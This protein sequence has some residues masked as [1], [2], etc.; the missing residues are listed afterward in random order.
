VTQSLL[1]IAF[2]GTRGIPASHGGFE[3]CA[4]EVGWRLASRGHQVTVY[5]EGRGSRVKSHRGMRI[6]HIPPLPL[7]GV[8][9]LVAA[10]LATLHALLLGRFDF[11]MVFDNAKAPVL[12]LLALFRRSYAINT[13]GLG[14]QRDKWG[15]FARKYYKWTEWLVTKLC[16]NV[17]TDS[18]AMRAYYL[19][20]YATDSTVIE[21]GANE[22]IVSPPEEER[23]LLRSWGVSPM[24]YFLQVTRFEPENNPLLSIQAFKASGLTCQ[25]VVVGGARGR[26]EYAQQMV[27]EARGVDRIVLPGFIYDSR[28]LSALWRNSRAYIHGNHIGGTNPALL[29]AMAAGRPVIARDCVFNREVLGED[30]YFYERNALS[31]SAN[32][33]LLDSDPERAERLAARA[34]EHVR[35]Y[36]CWNR[37]TDC[38]EQLFRRICS[39][40]QR[41]EAL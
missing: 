40:T 36:Y 6:V 2:I 15:R 10:T 1:R 24:S 35:K 23:L 13:D 3:T 18:T 39:E 16:G 4:E 26:S 32:M 11:F 37:I 33:R 41:G 19:S 14:W 8:D 21:Y 38:Y 9:A 20:E 28:Q 31:L 7:K 29:Q 5:S 22:P 25:I 34:L 17:V 12:G 27:Q 30:G